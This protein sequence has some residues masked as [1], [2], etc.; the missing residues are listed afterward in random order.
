MSKAQFGLVLVLAMLTG[1]IGGAATGL[2]AGTITSQVFPAKFLRAKRFEVV[3]KR[4]KILAA[5]DQSGLTFFAREGAQVSAALNAELG[6]F[7]LHD[8]AANRRVE[9]DTNS[10]SLTLYDSDGKP[11]WKIPPEQTQPRAQFSSSLP[12]EARP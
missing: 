8:Q 2:I 7:T 12:P 10:L 1:L 4:G 11:V 6:R 5:L 3:N 9:L